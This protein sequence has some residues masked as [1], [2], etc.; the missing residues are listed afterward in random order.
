ME[1]IGTGRYFAGR[2]TAFG[3]GGGKEKSMKAQ[4]HRLG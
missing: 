3:H 1:S 2:E 4:G